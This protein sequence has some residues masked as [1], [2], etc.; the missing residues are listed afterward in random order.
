MAQQIWLLRHG[1]AE[2]TGSGTDADRR[3]TVRGEQESR[4]AGEGL[5]ALGVEFDAVLSS[6]RVRA[7][8][9]A[10]LAAAALGVEPAVHDPLSGDFGAEEALDMLDERDVDARVLLVGHEP[11]FSQVIRELTGA[12][13][14]LKKGGVAAVRVRG[15][16]GELVVLLRPRDLAA[17]SGA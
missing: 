15:R 4:W 17:L 16:E 5:A 11:D 9:T 8:D 12:Q 13:I 1:E 10:R 6:P 3:L 14:H 2:P 7:R